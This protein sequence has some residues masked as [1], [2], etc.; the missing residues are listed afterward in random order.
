MGAPDNACN[1]MYPGHGFDAQNND[2]VPVTF[3]VSPE[4]PIAPGQTVTVTLEANKGEN[5][6]KGFFVQARRT[7]SNN[8]SNSI[9]DVEALEKELL[10]PLGHFDTEEAS[11]LTCGR[12]IHNAITSKCLD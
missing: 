6:F 7:K 4:G 3:S 5:G 10:I 11:Y 9:E 12:G 8:E 2:Q 1:K